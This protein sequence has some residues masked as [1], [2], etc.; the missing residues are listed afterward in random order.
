[1]F[2]SNYNN[3]VL[4][5]INVISPESPSKQRKGPQVSFLSNKDYSRKKAVPNPCA[6]DLDS[7]NSFC[8]TVS[9]TSN[10]RF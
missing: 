3:S 1:M 8:N 9:S 4:S 7:I 2:G 5:K 6:N 10:S